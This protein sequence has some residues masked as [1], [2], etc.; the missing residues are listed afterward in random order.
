MHLGGLPIKWVHN[1][2][3]AA[4]AGSEENFLPVSGHISFGPLD[5]HITLQDSGADR[6]LIVG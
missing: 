3:I 4:A 5:A 2:E 1:F 6:I